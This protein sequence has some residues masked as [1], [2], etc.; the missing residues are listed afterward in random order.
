MALSWLIKGG[1]QQSTT[2]V[3]VVLMRHSFYN[4]RM[5]TM[6]SAGNPTIMA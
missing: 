4:K 5:K 2:L 6:S 1:M 3:V